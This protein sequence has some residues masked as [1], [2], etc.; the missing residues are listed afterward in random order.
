MFITMMHSK[1]SYDTK[2]ITYSNAGHNPLIVYNS[3]TKQ[4]E[5]HSVKGVAIGFLDDYNY[6]Q[7]EIHLNIGDIVI[8]YTDGITEAE[9]QNKELFGIDRL[10]DVLLQNSHL[11][12]KEIKQKLLSEINNFQNGCE[13][14]DDITF[15]IIKREE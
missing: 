8:Y 9:N 6:K 1:Y 5:T 7:D 15:V 3:S 12:S 11:S 2:T 13:Q 14:S 4:V 10:K